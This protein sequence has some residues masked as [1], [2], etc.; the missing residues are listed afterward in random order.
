MP[1]S[2]FIPWRHTKKKTNDDCV[3]FIVLVVKL[4]EK[5]KGGVVK[6]CPSALYGYDLLFHPIRLYQR[7]H[8]FGY[9][10]KQVADFPFLP[11][12]CYLLFRVLF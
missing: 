10:I 1:H 7:N 11:F 5:R 4:V 8:L 12:N 6:H 2:Y 9:T 3:F